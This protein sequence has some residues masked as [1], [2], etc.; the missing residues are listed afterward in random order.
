MVYRWGGNDY[1]TFKSATMIV[2]IM[3]IKWKLPTIK[4]T[5]NDQGFQAFDFKMK[6]RV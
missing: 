3:I 5:L 2:H 1:K 4:K 6:S